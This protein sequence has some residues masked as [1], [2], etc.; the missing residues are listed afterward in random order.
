MA[1]AAIALMAVTGITSCDDGDDGYWWGPDT[2]NSYYDSN[3]LGTWRLI[4]INEQTV[5]PSQTNYLEFTA[6]GG[7]YYFYYSGGIQATQRIR[8]ICN[9][10]FNRDTLTIQYQDGH[11]STMNYYFTAGT[12]YL[13]LNW[14]TYTGRQMTYCY[15]YMGSFIPW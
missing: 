2:G 1:L 9:A 14:T 7:G 5:A 11:Q 12:D 8:W 4:Q 13:Y 10:G 15:Q 3:L 6:N